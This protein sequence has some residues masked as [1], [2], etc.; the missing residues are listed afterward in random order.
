MLFIAL[1]S[2]PLVALGLGLI[3]SDLGWHPGL[4]GRR[5]RATRATHRPLLYP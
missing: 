2:L 5:R 1:L 4:P 3:A